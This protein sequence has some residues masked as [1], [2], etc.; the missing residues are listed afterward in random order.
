[1]YENRVIEQSADSCEAKEYLSSTQKSDINATIS[2]KPP[3]F[4]QTGLQQDEE[5]KDSSPLDYRVSC[6]PTRAALRVPDTEKQSDATKSNT[7]ETG[8]AEY[9]NSQI[10]ANASADGASESDTAFPLEA[11]AEDAAAEESVHD[12]KNYENVDKSEAGGYLAAGNDRVSSTFISP[13]IVRGSNWFTT[14]ESENDVSDDPI[15][16]VESAHHP[17]A[18]A[19]ARS[20]RYPTPLRDTLRRMFRN[21]KRSFSKKWRCW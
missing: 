5:H 13:G 6:R 18:D 20:S 16:G 17:S 21:R 9:Y 15:Y 10:Y 14:E 8:S 1:M 12:R 7:T 3:S 4:A 2:G 11:T 19:Y